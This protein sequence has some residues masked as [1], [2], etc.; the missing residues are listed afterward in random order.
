MRWAWGCARRD[1][2]ARKR[3]L[4]DFQNGLNGAATDFGN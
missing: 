3:M 2:R 1:D 4:E